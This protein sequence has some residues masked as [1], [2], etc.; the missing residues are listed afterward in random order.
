MKN[1]CQIKKLSGGA[2]G[3]LN[4]RIISEKRDN[5]TS[6]FPISTHLFNTFAL[7]LWVRIDIL[8]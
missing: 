8:Y 3:S 5:L 6:P 2:L 7:L 4:Y 1:I